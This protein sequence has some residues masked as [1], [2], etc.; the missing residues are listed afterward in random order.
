LAAA[1]LRDA[2]RVRTPSWAKHSTVVCNM[3][4]LTIRHDEN[5]R[6]PP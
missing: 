2:M 6:E 4:R 5:T 3:Y 1:A